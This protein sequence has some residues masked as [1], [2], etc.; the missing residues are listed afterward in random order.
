MYKY[1]LET[2]LSIAGLY[3]NSIFKFLKNHLKFS[4]VAIPFYMPTNSPQG[5]L[6][7]HIFDTTCFLG[8]FSYCFL[9]NSHLMGVRWGIISLKNIPMLCDGRYEIVYSLNWSWH[10]IFIFLR[11]REIFTHL[12]R[13]WCLLKLRCIGV[14][15]QE[16]LEYTLVILLPS[17]NTLPALCTTGQ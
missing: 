14:Y 4:I 7:L 17:L 11:F 5:F 6:F 10:T 3:G 15:E 12:I 8:S 2:L 16:T 9:D 13:Y 1:L